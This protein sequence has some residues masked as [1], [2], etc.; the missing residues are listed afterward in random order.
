MVAC[1]PP[2]LGLIRTGVPPERW[3]HSRK[4]SHGAAR[5]KCES[6]FG[7]HSFGVLVI[8]SSGSGMNHAVLTGS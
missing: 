3:V 1:I 5:C 7:P 4:I 2:L 6:G 8:G